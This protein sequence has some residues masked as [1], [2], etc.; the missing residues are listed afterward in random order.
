[1]PDVNARLAPAG[2]LIMVQR[3]ASEREVAHVA[4]EIG[5][6]RTTA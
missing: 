1:M 6:L 2:G 5:I 4:E 3:I